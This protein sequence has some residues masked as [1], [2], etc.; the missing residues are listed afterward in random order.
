MTPRA[1]F[2]VLAPREA[3]VIGFFGLLLIAVSIVGGAVVSFAESGEVGSLEADRIAELS[4]IGYVSGSE[5]PRA[6]QGV[7]RHDRARSAAGF[8]LLTSGHA[9]VALLMDMDGRVVHEWTA[10]FEDV[11]PDHPRS[12]GG[13]PIRR[14]FWREAIL[15]PDGGI[16]VIWELFGIFKLDRNSK[17]VW[18]VPE[19]AHHDLQ[20]DDLGQVVHLQAKRR[21]IP[22]IPEQPSVE[23]FIVTR[24]EEGREVGRVALS[25]ALRNVNWK[26]LRLNFWRRAKARGYG[27]DERSA[28]DP[29]HTNSLRLLSQADAANLGDPF[30]A[31]DALVSMAMLD[32]VAIIDLDQ[33]LTRWSQQGPFGMQH[34]ARMTPAGEILLFNNFETNSESSVIALDPRTRAVVWSYPGEGEAALRSRRSGGVQIL[35]NGNRLITETDGGRALEVTPEGD[36]VWEFR[37]PYRAGE[38][39]QKVAHLYSLERVGEEQAGWL[40]SEESR[41]S[42]Q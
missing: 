8:N 34:S 24:D 30:K 20:L 32:T 27:L 17:V 38:D 33:G 31:G 7:V 19:P 37:S 22:G 12:G 35:E 42:G 9:P 13:Q 18:A 1:S 2:S 36:V 23:D 14:N 41:D 21:L 40:G 28:F 26:K 3:G 15:L 16:I 29:F 39:G 25:D 6:G 11:F 4:A 10:A 5:A